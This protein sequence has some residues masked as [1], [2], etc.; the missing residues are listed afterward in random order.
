MK[1]L[2]I[3]NHRYIV[4]EIGMDRIWLFDI[5]HQDEEEREEIEETSISKEILENVE[6]GDVLI[7][8]EGN[9]QVVKE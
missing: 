1:Q 5:T 8:K 9:Y 2:I 4:N 7:Y 3:E 6:I